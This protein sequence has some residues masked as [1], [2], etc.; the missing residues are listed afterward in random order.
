MKSFGYVILFLT[1]IA[2]GIIW[3]VLRRISAGT[4][5]FINPERYAIQRVVEMQRALPTKLN[6]PGETTTFPV[7]RW[8][9]LLRYDPEIAPIAELLR[10]F[11]EKWVWI[12]GRDYF[13]LQEDRSYLPHILDRLMDEAQKRGPGSGKGSGRAEGS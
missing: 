2:I 11:G 10:P 9:A 12:L 8:N 5:A 7:D 13:A 1:I 3:H 6:L 4:Q